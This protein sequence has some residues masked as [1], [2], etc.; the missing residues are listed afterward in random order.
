M[1]AKTQLGDTYVKIHY[2]S[3][4]RRHPQSGEIRTIFGGIVPYGQVW[5]TGANEAT[6]ITFTGDLMVG[7][8]HLPA[9]TYAL[10][11]IPGETEW[12]VI[13]SKA[14]GQWGSFSYDQAQDAARVTVP[15]GRSDKTY[16][17]FT[18][19]FEEAPGGAHLVLAWENTQVRVP[20]MAH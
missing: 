20:V 9:G 13:L 3:P 1:L 16:E 15:A 7:N 11:T 10:Y 17:A 19:A 6:E 18:I 8:A 14:V 12:T 4:Q 2:G 5:R